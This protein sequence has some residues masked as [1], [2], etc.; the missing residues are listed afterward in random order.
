MPGEGIW[1]DYMTADNRYFHVNVC[2]TLASTSCETIA[3]VAL[4]HSIGY[5]PEG[6]TE[7]DTECSDRS[8][9]ILS[10]DSFI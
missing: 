2:A 7:C 10:I 3:V 1:D 4:F 5:D 6:N 9:N 8:S